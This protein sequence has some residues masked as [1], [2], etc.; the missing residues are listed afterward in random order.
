VQI[1]LLGKAW[2]DQTGSFAIK[3]LLVSLVRTGAASA[4]MA[5]AIVGI[6]WGISHYWS[7]GGFQVSNAVHL[8]GSMAVGGIVF[9]A[10]AH[11]LGC[12]ETRLLLEGLGRRRAKKRA[13]A[14]AVPAEAVAK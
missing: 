11:V 4:G 14:M 5:A 7:F 9:W 8:F 6:R 10:M 13:V 12:P 3:G 2:R 1:V